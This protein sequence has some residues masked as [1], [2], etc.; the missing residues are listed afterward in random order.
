MKIMFPTINANNYLSK[1]DNIKSGIHPNL[2]PLKNDMVSFS[3]SAKLIAE[4]MNIAPSQSICTSAAESAEPARFYLETVLNKHIGKYIDSTDEKST[5]KF[6]V[7]DCTTRVKSPV[8]IREKVVSKYSKLYSSSAKIFVNDVYDALSRYFQ[9]THKC[10]KDEVIKDVQGLVNGFDPTGSSLAYTNVPLYFSVA[11]THIKN[12]GYF[13]FSNINDEKQNIIFAEIIDDIESNDHGI[14]PSVTTQTKEGVKH[15]ANDIVGARIILRDSD[16]VNT[17][18]VIDALK[19]AVSAGE[20]KITSIENNIPDP[21]KLPYGKSIS[22]YAYATDQQLNSLARESGIKCDPIT[23]KSGYLAIHINVDLSNYKFSK[24]N[25]SFDGYQGEIQIIGRDV[26]QLK[27]IEDLCYKLKDHKNAI[28]SEYLPFK[29]HFL[30]YYTGE[31]KKAFNDYTYA[32]YL[33]QRSVEF[34]PKHSTFP[35]LQLLGFD[36]VLPPELDFNVLKGIKEQCDTQVKVNEEKDTEQSKKNKQKSIV[37]QNL[38]EDIKIAKSII[39]F[40]LK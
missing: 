27:E 26:A 7:L 16:P 9:P 3:A 18:K 24:F 37:H 32:L 21:E 20:L 2:S 35:S 4:H 30:K 8:S 19:E 6:P 28:K 31:N 10:S 25:R 23:S 1:T 5:K 15:Y 34:N 39:S 29:T 17:G 12:N 38:D 40:L 33:A 22:S 13:D 11:L 36:D 14:V